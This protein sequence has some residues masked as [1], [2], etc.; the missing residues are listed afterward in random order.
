MAT[1]RATCRGSGRACRTCATSVFDGIWLTPFYPSP[2]HDHGYDVSDYLDV[3]PRFGN[4]A[5]PTRSSPT[6]T[7]SR[8]AW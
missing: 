4:L 5:D 3:D 8:C 2:G 6:R 1:A 7:I